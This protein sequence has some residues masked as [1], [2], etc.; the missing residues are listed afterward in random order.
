MGDRWRVKIKMTEIVPNRGN[1]VETFNQTIKTMKNMKLA[2]EIVNEINEV[3]N[4]DLK[5]IESSAMTEVINEKL[6]PI[7]KIR[8]ACENNAAPVDLKSA[9]KEVKKVTLSTE[10]IYEL[11][12]PKPRK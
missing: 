6:K 2:T 10:L 3:F 1:K 9:L 5:T 12:F 4:L 7:E 11:L 8:K